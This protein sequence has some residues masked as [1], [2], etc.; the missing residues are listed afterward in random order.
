MELVTVEATEK[1]RAGVSAWAMTRVVKSI[2][3]FDTEILEKEQGRNERKGRRR[4][5]QR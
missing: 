1:V 4:K 2:R 3:D 5:R